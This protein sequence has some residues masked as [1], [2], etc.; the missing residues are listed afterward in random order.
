MPPGYKARVGC[1]ET[2][3]L[4]DRVTGSVGDKAMGKALIEAWKRDG[5]LQ[6]SSEQIRSPQ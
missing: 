6:I 3:R 2:F 4:P 5:I 1:L